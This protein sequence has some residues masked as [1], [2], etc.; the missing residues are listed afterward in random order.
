M[1]AALRLNCPGF[2]RLAGGD[3]QV[4]RLE[5]GKLLRLLQLLRLLNTMQ[6]FFRSTKLHCPC[7]PILH[8]LYLLT[9]TIVFLMVLLLAQGRFHRKNQ[10]KSV[11]ICKTSLDPPTPG[12][13][14]LRIKK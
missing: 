12:L 4:I 9:H 2:S 11:V 5:K 10:V 14:F 3:Q 13:V 8:W 6:R 7:F 1:G